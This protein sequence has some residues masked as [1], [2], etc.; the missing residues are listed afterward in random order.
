MPRRHAT[1][2]LHA[3]TLDHLERHARATGESRAALA[4][5]LLEEGL[6]LAEHPQIAFRDGALG[7]RPVLAG[8]RL[9]VSQVVET[10]RN[11]GKSIE[12]AAEYLAISPAKVRAARRYYSAY[13][14][15]IDAWI[16][17]AREAAD[18]EEQSWRR[19]QEVLA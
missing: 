15:E 10:V 4:E 16:E 11:S 9:D 2:R 1:F 18:R 3:D 12:E 13:K 19:E 8:T 6:R 14:D 5:R 7:R 17:R